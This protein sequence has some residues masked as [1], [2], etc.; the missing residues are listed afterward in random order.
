[1]KQCHAFKL[2]VM[3]YLRKLV[4]I[5][6]RKY[7]YHEFEALATRHEYIYVASYLPRQCNHKVTTLTQCF[8]YAKKSAKEW[9]NIKNNLQKN[10]TPNKWPSFTALFFIIDTKTPHFILAE[11][12]CEKKRKNSYSPQPHCQ[13]RSD[14]KM[15][16]A[17]V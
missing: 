2:F 3:L 13:C 12:N 11:R 16:A 7:T 9:Y 4:T 6:T 10:N 1:M 5:S 8:A 15:A 14:V 17:T